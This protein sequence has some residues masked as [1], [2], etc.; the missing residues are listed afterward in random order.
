MTTDAEIRSAMSIPYERPIRVVPVGEWV[1]WACGHASVAVRGADLPMSD[2]VGPI[3]NR[4]AAQEFIAVASAPRERTVSAK[5]LATWCAPHFLDECE[6]CDGAGHTTIECPHPGCGHAHK[7]ECGLCKGTGVGDAM[8][9]RTRPVSV[10]GVMVDARKLAALLA[11]F[12]DCNVTIARREWR[13]TSSGCL[14]AFGDDS[15]VAGLAPVDIADAL[16]TWGAAT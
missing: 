7:T 11:I 10:L 2:D 1:M 9:E 8:A 3:V 16:A 15:T 12:G 14:L 4:M 13:T 5:E 6:R